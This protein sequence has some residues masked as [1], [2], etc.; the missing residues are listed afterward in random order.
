MIEVDF[1]GGFQ[2]SMR[3]ECALVCHDAQSWVVSLRKKE[4]H[5]ILTH[6]LLWLKVQP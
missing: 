5:Y 3:V 6:E 4:E 1:R 2:V